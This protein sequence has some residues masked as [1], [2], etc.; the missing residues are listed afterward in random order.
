MVGWGA[1]AHVAFLHNQLWELRQL[2]F[3]FNAEDVAR[4]FVA[5]T[6]WYCGCSSSAGGVERPSEESHWTQQGLLRIGVPE[7]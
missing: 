5:D 7:G 2:S 6:T 1:C 4:F 3:F